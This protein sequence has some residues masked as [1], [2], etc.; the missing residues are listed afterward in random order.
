MLAETK[1]LAVASNIL[2]LPSFI[3]WVSILDADMFLMET[4]ES[5]FPWLQV[6]YK[7]QKMLICLDYRLSFPILVRVS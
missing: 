7:E 1:N 3:N 2:W 6:I 5:L 4:G